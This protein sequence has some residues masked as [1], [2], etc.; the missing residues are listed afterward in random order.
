MDDVEDLI[1]LPK[2][3]KGQQQ[4][5]E[6]YLMLVKTLPSKYCSDEF[7][8]RIDI[9]KL[10]TDLNMSHEGVYKWMR[11]DRISGHQATKLIDLSDGNLT[12]EDFLPF[13]F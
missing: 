4:F 8:S 2:K 9:R 3:K 12:R 7:E 10:A 6:L 11:A 13:V 5:G 1:G